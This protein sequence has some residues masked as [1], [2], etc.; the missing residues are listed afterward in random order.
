MKRAL[1]LLL[2]ALVPLLARAQDGGMTK[3]G[4]DSEKLASEMAAEAKRFLASVKIAAK[5]AVSLAQKKQPGVVVALRAEKATRKDKAGKEEKVDCF[6]ATIVQKLE[7][8]PEPGKEPPKEPLK[9]PPPSVFSVQVDPEGK[10]TSRPASEEEA[11]DA[12]N[13]IRRLTATNATVS[14]PV[15]I[16]KLAS[17]E[18]ASVVSVL[19]EDREDRKDK[20]TE[21]YLVYALVG[22]RVV[23]YEV[24]ATTGEVSKR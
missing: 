12:Q 9:E 1:P 18:K 16:E 13:V 14:I 15:V 17:H 24:D 11:R 6:E 19:L 7:A 3:E 20:K 23:W 2:V 10:A 4:S 21:A 5:D 22:D 8:T